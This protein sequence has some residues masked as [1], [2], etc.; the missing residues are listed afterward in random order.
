[1]ILT[2]AIVLV[3]LGFVLL[4]IEVFL[5]PGTAVSGI[6]G[7]LCLIGGVLTA[8]NVNHT[9]GFVFLFGSAVVSVLLS[10]KLLKAETWNKVT[11]S[12]SISARSGSDNSTVKIGDK[13]KSITRLNPMGR[14][15]LG[16]EYAEVT[17]RDSF[18]DQGIDI[19]VVK[20]ERNKIFVEPINK[21][22]S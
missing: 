6:L 11:N 22:K 20:I 19:E 15:R 21:D 17:A 18:I 4:L 16:E 10:I 5:M 7:I 2:A 8:F 14:A 1:M 9:Y 3:I 13:G 12:V